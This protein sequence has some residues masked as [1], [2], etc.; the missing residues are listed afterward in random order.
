MEQ[1]ELMGQ[2]QRETSSP[3][4][5]DHDDFVVVP[6]HRA[7]SQGDIPDVFQLPAFHGIDLFEISIDEL[8]HH[9]SSGSLTSWEYTR[10][11]L[12]RIQKVR[13]RLCW[14]P[15]LTCYKINP[16]LECVI[17]TNPDALEHARVLDDE[18][19][20]GRIKGP[21]HGVPVLVKDVGYLSR[22]TSPFRL[23]TPSSKGLSMRD[24]RR[25]EA[26]SRPQ[27]DL[28]LTLC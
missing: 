2:S 18:R 13:K 6:S 16:Y 25:I 28:H 10:M 3:A 21:L 17:E 12:K 5:Y 7:Q 24:Q 1:T 19:L 27:V 9:F 11:C 23:G 22:C 26:I 14:R 4:D 15:L 20:K 8:Q